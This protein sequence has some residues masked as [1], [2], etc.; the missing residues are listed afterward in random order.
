MI[1]QFKDIKSGEKFT[2]LSGRRT[3]IKLQDT[4]PSGIK[5]E[6]GS[7]CKEDCQFAKKGDHITSKFN[8]IDENG[9]PGNCPDWLEFDVIENKNSRELEKENRELKARIKILE[10]PTDKM[11]EDAFAEGYTAGLDFIPY[12]NVYDTNGS[13]QKVSDAFKIGYESGFSERQAR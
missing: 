8:S 11:K 6:Y 10:G 1:K 3:F 4:L 13:H 12:N 7:F 5:V 9:I 2:E